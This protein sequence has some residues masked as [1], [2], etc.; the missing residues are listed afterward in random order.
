MPGDNLHDWSFVSVFD[1]KGPFAA[2]LK[3]RIRF[4]DEQQFFLMPPVHVAS[5]SAEH[6]QGVYWAFESGRFCSVMPVDFVC[7][8]DA[9]LTQ[10]GVVFL[11]SGECVIE[12]IYPWTADNVQHRF[13]TL[14]R[15][16]GSAAAIRAAAVDMAQMDEVVHLREPGE[17]GY[18][19][20]INSVMPRLV[21]ASRIHS[22]SD[23]PF[24]IDPTPQF[25]SESLAV[26][27]LAGH[28]LTPRDQ[29][30]RVKRLWMTGPTN[31]RGDH[32]TRQPFWT[33]EVRR[34]L[35]PKQSNSNSRM[36]YLSRN[37]SKVRRV[38]NEDRLV[39]F[40]K[41]LGFEILTTTGMPMAEQISLFNE[42]KVLLSPHGAGL[43][44][45]IFMKSG[46]VVE[47]VSRSRLWPTFRTLAGRSGLR[48]AAFISDFEPNQPPGVQEGN[49]DITIDMEIFGKF[50][51]AVLEKM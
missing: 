1:T 26:L 46:L 38:T 3:E 9:I 11:S 48:Y 17:W 16:M 32:F 27:G 51:N 21:L 28:P 36:V 29:A 47:I 40:L 35:A 42:A 49:E 39:E 20:W 19:H 15:R 6:E 8:E 45:A 25:A 22:L 10:E 18:F 12:S 7:I 33:N 34:R 13:A 31:L 44:N 4:A 14:I 37:D 30:Y 2:R 43:S 24:A 5:D 50:C 23:K 41:P